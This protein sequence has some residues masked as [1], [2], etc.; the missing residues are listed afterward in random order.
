[1]KLPYTARIYTSPHG[2]N[3]NSHSLGAGI[4]IRLVCRFTI[5]DFRAINHRH[6]PL[7]VQRIS[8]DIL[9]YIYR[10][11]FRFRA[12]KPIFRLVL[13]ARHRVSKWNEKIIIMRGNKVNKKVNTA[14]P[15]LFIYYFIGEI[16]NCNAFLGEFFIWESWIYH[17]K[18]SW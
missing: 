16:L 11:D 1:M 12:L 3:G 13:C 10:L 5:R 14:F 9:Y 4:R 8:V 7:K 2:S 17:E 6:C 15:E 18:C